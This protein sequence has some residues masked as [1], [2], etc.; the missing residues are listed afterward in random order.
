MLFRSGGIT[1]PDFSLYYKAVIIKT[2][3]YWYKNRHIDQWNRIETPELDPQMYGQLIFDK[4]E[5][6]IQWKKDC[7]F[8]KWCWEN[9][10]ATCRIL[11]LDHFLKPYTRTNSKWM[12]DL[13]MRQESNEILQ[14]KTGSDIL[15]LSCSKLFLDMSLE[16]RE[17]KA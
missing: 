5:K 15:D 10:T 2:T 16:A 17:R 1:I 8:S 3:C 7:F 12:E 6:T 4:A 14:V 13:N 9:W 11:K